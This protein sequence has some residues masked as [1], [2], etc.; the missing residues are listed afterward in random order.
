MRRCKDAKNNVLITTIFFLQQPAHL[1]VR[2]ATRE[3]TRDLPHPVSFG[4]AQ[5]L[6]LGE[7]E[8]IGTPDTSA[9]C[10]SCVVG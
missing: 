1:L 5:Q 9:Q 10:Q 7:C 3:I 4:S 8:Q 6:K 2:R